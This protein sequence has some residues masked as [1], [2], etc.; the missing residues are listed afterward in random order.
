MNFTLLT[1]TDFTTIQ[2]FFA[3]NPY[4]LSVYSPSSLIAWSSETHP[5]YY[6]VIDGTLLVSSGVAGR[7]QDRHLILPIAATP[8]ASTEALYALA[9]EL[10]FERYGYVPGDF[11]ATFNRAEIEARFTVEEQSG[12]E[13]YIYLVEDLVGLKGNKFAKKRNLINQFAREYL[14]RNRVS[15]EPILPQDVEDCLAFLETWCNQHDYDVGHS[16]ACEKQALTTTL[17]NLDLF[18]SRGILIRI[19]GRICALGIA[20]PLNATTATLNYEKAFAEIKGLY[21]YLDNE[22]AKRLFGDYWYINKESDLNILSLA[23][24][25]ESYYP[26]LRIKSF[27]LSLR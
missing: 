6:A 21:Q 17:L 1:P 24:S 26:A 4:Q 3:A 16:L 20:S 12:Y 7:P 9:R 27:T 22:C 14:N 23:E 11:L 8:P 13:D 10:G 15:V 18:G 5:T 25:K 19:D 2:P